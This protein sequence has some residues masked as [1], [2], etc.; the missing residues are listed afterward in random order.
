ML[1]WTTASKISRKEFTDLSIWLEDFCI[2]FFLKLKRCK[3]MPKSAKSQITIHMKIK[4]QNKQNTVTLHCCGKITNLFVHGF[5]VSILFRRLRVE[6]SCLRAISTT[7]IP[8]GSR[9]AVSSA[10]WLHSRLRCRLG[11]YWSYR[12]SGRFSRLKISMLIFQT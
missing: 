10:Y 12:Y 5:L 4:P 3:I 8:S 2:Y 11:D 1:H 9:C 7:T 6:G